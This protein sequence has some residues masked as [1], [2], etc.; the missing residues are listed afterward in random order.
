LVKKLEGVLGQ[1]E[2][3]GNLA[4]PGRRHEVDFAAFDGRI[5]VGL[6]C[7]SG[8]YHQN[9]A[10]PAHSSYDRTP[11]GSAALSPRIAL[12]FHLH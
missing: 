3:L 4:F 10:Y 12:H 1:A 11:L 9:R 6:G 2:P 8:N 5:V 7:G